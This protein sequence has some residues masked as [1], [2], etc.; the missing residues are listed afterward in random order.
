MSRLLDLLRRQRARPVEGRTRHK[1]G[2]PPDSRATGRDAI[3]LD[4]MSGRARAVSWYR[5]RWFVLL[6]AIAAAVILVYVS[7]LRARPKAQL[8]RLV[9]GAP[10][11]LTGRAPVTHGPGQ[12]AARPEAPGAR[13]GSG[14]A[15]ALPRTPAGGQAA[16]VRTPARAAAADQ[17]PASAPA[18]PAAAASPRLAPPG[19]QAEPSGEQR[20]WL[21]RALDYQRIG[22]VEKA[23]A[24]YRVLLQANEANA[25]A[26]NNL[27]LLYEGKGLLEDAMREFARAIEIE[28]A[29]DKA[30]NNLGV[31]LL[32]TGNV[33]AAAAE[34]RRVLAANPDNQEAMIN[35]ALSQRADGHP[36]QARETLIR[37]VAINDRS[38]V[39][40]YNLALLYDDGGEIARALEHYEAYLKY[41]GS[42][43]PKALAAV[44]ERCQVLRQRLVRF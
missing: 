23:I 36:E 20:E 35:L 3:I 37:A 5:R 16:G 14:R 6:P 7:S 41:A 19:A 4:A 21:K 31:G 40:H 39:A 18:N 9:T 15:G 26:H 33:E 38:A 11:V 42:A 30:R 10:P 24:E 43:D 32:R 25:Q 34:F 22:E 29:Y 2:P 27:G 12:D 17:A 8:P 1:D 28:P 13:T 44:R